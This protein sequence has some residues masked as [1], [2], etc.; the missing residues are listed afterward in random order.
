MRRLKA[1]L[2]LEKKP[3]KTFVFDPKPHRNLE[4]VVTVNVKHKGPRDIFVH[5]DQEAFELA[6]K[7]SEKHHITDKAKQHALLQMLEQRIYD[8]RHPYVEPEETVQEEITPAKNLRK[9]LDPKIKKELEVAFND[10]WY[11]YNPRSGTIKFDKY[12]QVMKQ[13]KQYRKIKDAPTGPFSEQELEKQF[14]YELVT[15]YDDEDEDKNKYED[16]IPHKDVL[17]IAHDELCKQKLHNAEKFKRKLEFN[18]KRA[19][20]DAL[21][22]QSARKGDTQ[23]S[24]YNISKDQDDKLP[25]FYQQNTVNDHTELI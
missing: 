23:Q 25:S 20:V 13:L 6:S 3:A 10:I 15:V 24:I 7:F 4:F 2:L 11:D 18:Q 19:E 22:A 17:Y 8:H 12:M 9:P 5:D 21:K 14:V 1:N 16:Q